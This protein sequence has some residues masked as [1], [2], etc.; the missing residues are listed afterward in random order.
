MNRSRVFSVIFSP[1]VA[2]LGACTSAITSTPTITICKQTQPG[3]GAGFQFTTT[4]GGLG[5]PFGPFTLN[6]TQCHTMLVNAGQDHY[7]AFTEN[8]PAGWLLTNISCN[9]TTSL[10]TIVGANGNPG[11]QPGDNTVTIDLNEP[12]VTCTFV[13]AQTPHCCGFNLDLSTGQG[14]VIDPL[15]T[16]NGGNAYVTPPSTAWT[17][18]MPPAQWIQP[19]ASPTPSGNVPPGVYKYV[20]SF[21]PT[22]CAMG[23]LELSG[24]FAADND[25]G[26]MLDGVHIGTACTNCFNTAAV[27]FA[28]NPLTLTSHV[29]E[30]NVNNLGGF[31]GLIVN[32]HVK[33]ICP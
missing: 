16:V 2:L 33:R 9:A 15:W 24:T 3:G 8:V 13:N 27:P 7:N 22:P 10:V 12:H 30:I 23:H 11:F 25:A 14:T 6:D 21:T 31:S 17:V 4:N 5:S 19:V 28:V 18:N 32:A 26:A 1:L 29:L 20:V